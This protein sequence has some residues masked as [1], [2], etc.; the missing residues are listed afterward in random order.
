MIA[1]QFAAVILAAQDSWKERVAEAKVSIVDAIDRGLKEAGEGVVFHAELEGDPG[2]LVYSIDIA[3]GETSRNVHISAS[4]GSVVLNE[5]EDEDHSPEVKAV[6]IGLKDAVA[7]AGEGTVVEAELVLDN[8]KPIVVV[9]VFAGG[10]IA[11]VLVDGVSGKVSGEMKKKDPF[12][13]TFRED[14]ADLGPTGSNPYF[15][16]EPGYVLEFAGGDEKLAITVLDET[17]EVDGV[18]ARVVEE[19]E[20]E[21]DELIEVSRNFFAISKKTN[22]VYYFGE[23]VDV[24]KD[25]KVV[26]HDGAWRSGENGAVFGLMIPGTPILGGM[27]YQE[28]AP[29]VAMDRAE[30]HS[31][32]DTLDT[33][34]GK[35]ENCL[36]TIETTP[37]EPGAKEAK[38]YAPGVGLIRDADLRLVKYGRK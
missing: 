17:V 25:G 19:R 35:F 8:D 27:Y 4:D 26:S 28:I 32:T 10:R 13:R 33:P 37:L 3:Q 12:T 9:K 2:E 15:I 20:W 21:G 18:E 30:I 14:K 31:L 6:R 5:V 11:T 16:L 34:A 1:I 24:Y 38:V 23:D 36:T 29:E 7:A 22:S